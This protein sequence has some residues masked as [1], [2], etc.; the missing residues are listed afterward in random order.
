MQPFMETGRA[1]LSEEMALRLADHLDVPVRGRRCP[2]PSPLR[3][4]YEEV[5]GY[6]L[7]GTAGGREVAGGDGTYTPLALPMVLGHGGRV[8]SFITTIATFEAPMDVTVSE[9]ALESCLPTDPGTAAY[10][11][12]LTS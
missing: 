12:A 4:L 2:V 9:P 8:L 3:A 7:P 5:S 6:P 11:R 10:L 1:G